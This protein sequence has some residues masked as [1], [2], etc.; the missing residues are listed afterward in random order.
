VKRTAIGA[1]MKKNLCISLGIV[2]A[3]FLVAGNTTD[4]NSSVTVAFGGDTLLGG[5]YSTTPPYGTMDDLAQMINSYIQSYGEQEGIRRFVGYTFKNIKPIFARATY[6]VV[7]L[8]GPIVAA[9]D[10]SVPKVFS[11][12]QHVRTP[13]I[14]KQAG[15][16]LVS[17]ANNH[18]YD[19]NG[20]KGVEETM[21]RL[22]D[23]GI[24]YVG[25][26]RGEEAY[27]AAFGYKIKETN[28]LKIAFFG[29]TDVIEPEDM[30][31]QAEKAGVA[32]LR[33][34]SQYLESKNMHYLL[35]RIVEARKEADFCVVLLHA[36]P[37]RGRTLDPRQQEIVDILLEAGVDVIIGAHC[38][39]QQLIKEIHDKQGRLR[40]AAFYG[41]GNLVF[42]G[43]K[44]R[45]D[46]SL[47]VPL[48]PSIRKM[49]CATSLMKEFP[50]GRTRMA[51][52][53]RS[54]YNSSL[55]SKRGR[56]AR[57]AGSLQTEAVIFLNTLIHELPK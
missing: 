26:G 23:A 56:P 49:G 32:A 38:H 17:L 24:A 47:I 25:A 18:M 48:S 13:E 55:E 2:L 29:V 39:S 30:V 16:A 33:D 37:P 54:S 4:N 5:Y 8:E 15:I 35:G 7:N 11:L 12:R 3:L 42:G 20:S 43:C 10:T 34:Q 44:G 41:L 19:F 46:L 1:R 52:F 51:P 57:R 27:A 53:N 50:S 36:G 9:P 22:E 31:A 45:Q 21:Q 6:A 40:Q 28:G 14:L